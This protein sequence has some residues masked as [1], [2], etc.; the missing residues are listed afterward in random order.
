MQA[1]AAI[2][3]DEKDLAV[4]LGDIAR[5]EQIFSGWE[6]TP[7]YAVAAYSR[8][9][10]EL[11]GEA[12]RRLIKAL[13]SSPAAMTALKGALAD[14]VV[15]AVLRKHGIIKAGLP[16]RIETALN[17]V[18]PML[19][20]HGG[21]VDLI[22][23]EPPAVY[24]RFTGACDGCPASMV[25]FHEGVKKSIEEACPEITQVVQVKGAASHGGS[26]PLSPFA[27]LGVWRYA[28]RFDELAEGATAFTIEGEKLLLARRGDQVTCF[29]NAC[30][31][32]GLMLDGGEVKDGILE[33]PHHGFQYDLSSGECLTAPSVQLHPH[34]VRVEGK[35]VE[36][37]LSK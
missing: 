17:S 6:E 1:A 9:I 32:L 12:L 2:E 31:H 36:V 20:S 27:A 25:T 23:I 4:L 7:Q 16:E 35:N 10:E 29:K 5:L 14:E 3:P 15:Y 26:A 22:K 11:H 19:A 24:V 37:R 18:R 33:C 13:K 30:A 28:A 8:A 21:D 34:Q